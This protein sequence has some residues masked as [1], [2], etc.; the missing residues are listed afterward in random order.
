MCGAGEQSAMGMQ[1]ASEDE[2]FFGGDGTLR[3][4]FAATHDR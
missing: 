3:N 1:P 2:N 4:L